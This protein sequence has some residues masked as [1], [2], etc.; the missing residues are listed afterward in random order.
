M[1]APVPPEQDW[2]A[3]GR[4]PQGPGCPHGAQDILTAPCTHGDTCNREPASGL[5]ASCLEN[6]LPIPKAPGRSSTAQRLPRVCFLF[7]TGKSHFGPRDEDFGRLP[8]LSTPS[9]K[10]SRIFSK[11]F[12]KLQVPQMSYFSA[13]KGSTLVAKSK[14]IKICVYIYILRYVYI[15]MS[16]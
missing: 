4:S 2:K 8:P 13:L 9:L 5:Q 6:H 11:A 1:I 10:F 14:Y 16:L 12:E 3:G 7:F 15:Y